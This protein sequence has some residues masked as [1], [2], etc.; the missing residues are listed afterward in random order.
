MYVYIH[1]HTHI[2][3]LTHTYTHTHTHTHILTHTQVQGTRVAWLLASIALFQYEEEDTCMSYEEEDT[4]M[5]AGSWLL[6]PGPNRRA[7]SKDC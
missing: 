6:S 4:C 1:T 2:L 5:C 3:S 7:V